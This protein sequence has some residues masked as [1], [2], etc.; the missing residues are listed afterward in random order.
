[1]PSASW[2]PLR[3]PHRV[4][5]GHPVGDQQDLVRRDRGLEPRQLAHH[6]VV[7]L[8]PAGGVD[9]DRARPRLAR[10][11]DARRR[12]IFTT[13]VD[14]GLGVDADVDLLRQR[15]QLLDG[16]RTIHVGRDQER[17][18]LLQL[19]PLGEL[20]RRG[21]LARALQPDQQDDRRRHR[22]DARCGACFSPSSATSSS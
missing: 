21:R 12:T 17:R 14:A 16:G 10:R 9:D 18:L 22:R 4:L 3:D 8:Q 6:L 2:K 13:S 7:D 11:L 20:A 15:L 5:A 19:E 1:M